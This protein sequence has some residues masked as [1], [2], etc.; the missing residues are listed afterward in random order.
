MILS[1]LNV[2]L[3]KLFSNECNYFFGNYFRNKVF[4]EKCI[5]L[6]RE[7]LYRTRTQ[8]LSVF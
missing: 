2:C 8:E 3:G 6:P 1:A 5:A 7:E 4:A